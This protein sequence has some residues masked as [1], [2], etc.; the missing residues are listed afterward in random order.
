MMK[1]RVSKIL[2][3][4]LCLFSQAGNLA[5]QT[6]APQKFQGFLG[7]YHPFKGT[8]YGGDAGWTEGELMQKAFNFGENAIISQGAYNG[9]TFAENIENNCQ[10][11]D[12]NKLYGILRP[13]TEKGVINQPNDTDLMKPVQIEPGMIQGAK[14]FSELSKRC[15][16][17]SGMIIDDF[18]NDYPKLLS[19]ENL[20]DIKAALLGK[21][22]DESG[23]VDHL[24]N[25]ATPHL[26]LYIVVYEHQLDRVD[27]TVLDSIDGVSFWVWRQNENY[28]SFDGFIETL[29]KNYPGKGI[30]AGVYVFNGNQ[31]PAAASVHHIVERAIEFYA[32]GEINGLL[33][34]SAVWMSREKSSP[35]RWRELALP[36]FLGRVYYPFLGEATGRVRDAK[37]KN[38][39]KNA[40]VTVTR[41]AG[42]KTLLVARKITDERGEY[43]FGGW[44]GK[45]QRERVSYQIKI[46]NDSFKPRI[47]NVNLRA[48]ES[49]NIAEARLRREKN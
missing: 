16:Q 43:R 20:R 34:F 31:T 15:P 27:K 1:L 17:L 3:L 26:K 42:G 30:I 41:I 22:V 21:K 19:A 11:W 5:G 13:P 49:I 23:K 39:I 44:A 40:L 2:I 29:R 14:R 45:N 24:S 48:G 8:A 9:Y 38:P 46:E 6:P 10:N 7:S 32:K 33:V 12:V 4:L 37:T 18:F 47:I 28:K 36:Q 25:A 35:E